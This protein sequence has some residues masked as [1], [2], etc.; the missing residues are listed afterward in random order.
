VKVDDG[1]HPG[2]CYEGE[3]SHPNCPS[4]HAGD[5]RAVGGCQN[6]LYRETKRVISAKVQN[7]VQEKTLRFRAHDVLVM[8][9]RGGE[10]TAR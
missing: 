6:S 5:C 1:D 2:L 8:F 3:P 9:M 7:E 10:C 4:I